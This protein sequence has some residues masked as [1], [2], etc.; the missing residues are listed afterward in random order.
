MKLILFSVLSLCTMIGYAQT[1]RSFVCSDYSQNKVFVVEKGEIVWEH[2]APMTNDI[3]KL[4]NGNI[5]FTAGTAV[6]EMNTKGDTLFYY[7]S[8]SSIF[9]CQR[10]TSGNTMIAES[11]AARIIEVTPKGDIA[12]EVKLREGNHSGDSYIRLARKLD[13]GNYLVCHYSEGMVREYDPS[14]A[15]VW[16]AEIPEGAHSAVR[17]NNGHTLVSGADRTGDTRVRE[18]DTEG[19]VVWELSNA[20]VEDTKFFFFGGLHPQPNGNLVV[21]NWVGH[22]HFGQSM[23]AIE[24]TRDKKIVWE[25]SD[26]NKMKAISS[27]VITD[28]K[29]KK[30]YNH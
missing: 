10:L 7:Q 21:T 19:K 24:V 3:W 6:L 22:G 1:P 2:D 12:K 8:E 15:V 29:F 17:L 5:L 28:K 30:G 4:D 11:S 23:H 27:I 20:D 13:S 25:Y 9:A 26:H 18:F 16:K 14:G